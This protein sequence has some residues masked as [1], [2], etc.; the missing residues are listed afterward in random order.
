[1]LGNVVLALVLIVIVGAA[2]HKIINDK[3]KGIAC[4]SCPYAQQGNS[5]GCSCPSDKL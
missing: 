5:C 1:M 3:K 2:L 4:S